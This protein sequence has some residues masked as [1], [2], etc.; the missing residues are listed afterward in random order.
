MTTVT[1]GPEAKNKA[2]ADGKNGEG[3]KGEQEGACKK[4]TI[5]AVTVTV[6]ILI[7][8]I[9]FAVVYTNSQGKSENLTFC[10]KNKLSQY[11]VY[12]D[13]GATYSASEKH[14]NEWS[15][16]GLNSTT[17]FHNLNADQPFWVQYSF[18][19]NT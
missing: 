6:I 15:L 10:E 19:E 8:A 14:S 11:L 17:G 12:K 3:E 7:I 18:P 1:E 13:M 4:S 5:A 2:D 9:V 16:P